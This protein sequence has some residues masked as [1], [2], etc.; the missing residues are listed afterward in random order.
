MNRITIKYLI[1]ACAATLLMIPIYAQNY[2][3][4]AIGNAA[5]ENQELNG[6]YKETSANE[7]R[8]STKPEA[9]ITNVRIEE[10]TNDS[11]QAG[12]WV[13]FSI[14]LR[15]LSSKK[16]YA[17]AWFHKDVVHQAGADQEWE[18]QM[19]P[20]MVICPSADKWTKP[21]FAMFVPF[22]KVDMIANEGVYTCEIH[23]CNT[24]YVSL[25]KSNSYSFTIK[26]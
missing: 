14:E 26:R 11:G 19:S 22:S 23:I 17:S 20:N 5:V 12:V 16:C 7:E 8:S 10:G 2:S 18:L 9:N 4:K 25:G 21:D 6:G 13:R 15:G 3:S 1:I 24:E